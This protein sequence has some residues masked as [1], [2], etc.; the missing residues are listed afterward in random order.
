MHLIL[1]GNSIL[2]NRILKVKLI[3]DLARLERAVS[4]IILVSSNATCTGC[5][6]HKAY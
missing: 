6:E 1:G 5:R 4:T 3:L 2:F